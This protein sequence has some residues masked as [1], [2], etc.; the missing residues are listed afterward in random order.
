MVFLGTLQI[1]PPL[2]FSLREAAAVAEAER[3][4]LL[5]GL[6]RGM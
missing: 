6:S 1:S 4:F 2:S 3:S 5:L